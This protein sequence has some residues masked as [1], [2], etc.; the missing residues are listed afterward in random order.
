VTSLTRIAASA[1]ELPQ[2]LAPL[3]RLNKAR[4]LNTRGH[5][6]ANAR[7]DGCENAQTETMR[8]L[9][10]PRDTRQTGLTE[11]TIAAQNGSDRCLRAM[12][13]FKSKAKLDRA[14]LH[15]VSSEDDRV[16]VRDNR[17]TP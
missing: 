9:L 14:S 13:T 11:K 17:E 10:P 7:T 6:R 1:V 2:V 5:W 3:L 4:P 12:Q 8:T 16:T 15:S